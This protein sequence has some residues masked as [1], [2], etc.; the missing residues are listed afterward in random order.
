MPDTIHSIEPNH[1]NIYVALAAAQGEMGPVYKG[2]ENPHFKSSY[3]DLADV[4]EAVRDPLNR[5][6][7]AFFHFMADGDMV[8]MLMHGK[9]Q[10]SI[11]CAIPL[12]VGKND[13]QGMKSATT[14][15]KRIGLE[16]VTGI[17]PEDDDGNA[18]AANP[19]AARMSKAKSRD[20]Y[21]KLQSGLRNQSSENAINKWWSAFEADIETMHEDFERQ[22]R[23]EADAEIEAHRANQ[24]RRDTAELIDG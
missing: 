11:Y 19:E 6:G 4:V 22:L 2:S 8:T 9:S 21:A 1:P 14:Y 17:A 15:A 3:A 7:I 18:A 16:S 12:L 10:T 23:E 20:L 13:M 5:H 24:E